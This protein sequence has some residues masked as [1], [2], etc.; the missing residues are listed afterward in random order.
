LPIAALVI[1]VYVSECS[2]EKATVNISKKVKIER[3]RS[4]ITKKKKF[5]LGVV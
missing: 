1:S 2:K 4:T 5:F 3:F